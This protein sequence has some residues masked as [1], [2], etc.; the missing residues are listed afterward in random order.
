MKTAR[1]C[2][3]VFVALALVLFVGPARATVYSLSEGNSTIAIDAGSQSGAYGWV[4]DGS[5]VLYQ[6]WFWYGVGT[7]ADASID[8]LPLMGHLITT[9]LEGDTTGL[10]LKYGSATTFEIDIKYTLAGGAIGSHRSDVG[11]VIQIDNKE[12]T[13]LNFHF[14][15]YSDFDLNGL[16]SSDNVVLGPSVAGYGALQTSATGGPVLSETV[17]TP[18]PSHVE[19]N[20]YAYTLGK[21]NS[22][23]PTTLDGVTAAGPGD[24]TWAFEWDPTI[25]AGGSYIISKDKNISP[26]AVPEPTAILGLGT[27]LLLVGRKLSRR[28]A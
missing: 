25:A 11:E 4:V 1:W 17:A 13:P 28:E 26:S 7:S 18:A 10:E 16:G 24:V 6:Q 23:N 2:S 21:L 19:A 12:S 27:I 5:N 3:V 8:S 14:F 9:D 22:G 15:Q 20:Y